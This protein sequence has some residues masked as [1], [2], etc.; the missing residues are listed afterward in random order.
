MSD[1]KVVYR[2]KKGNIDKDRKPPKVRA[3]RGRRVT[4]KAEHVPLGTGSLDQAANAIK[5][6]KA[7]QD[8]RIKQNGG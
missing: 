2:D 6:R 1:R 3:E 4:G 8:A 5:N 7:A